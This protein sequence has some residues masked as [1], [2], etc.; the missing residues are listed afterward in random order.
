MTVLAG[1][2]S[3]IIGDK[4]RTLVLRGTSI[5]IQWGNK[6][7]DL[8]K[9]GKI[10]TEKNDILK[11]A[12][13]VEEIG[14]NGIYLVG[15]EVWISINGTKMLLGSSTAQ[16][17][18]F[19]QEQEL[20]P[21]QKQLAQS[22]MG[23][24]Y[25]TI[26]DIDNISAGIVFVEEDNSL[27]L[28]R[29]G[30]ATKYS[31]QETIEPSLIINA[32]EIIA[33][34][35]LLIKVNDLEY[36]RCEE[37]QVKLLQDTV[38]YDS[39]KFMSEDATSD[40]GFR[41][42]ETGNG[43]VLE[44]DTIILRKEIIRKTFVDVT[45]DE[46]RYLIETD[47][48]VMNTQ[49]RLTDYKNFWEMEEDSDRTEDRWDENNNLLLKNTRP[50]IVK[51]RTE[52]TYYQDECW[53]E[54]FPL[55]TISYDVTFN[56]RHTYSDGHSEEARGLITR[57]KD[58]Y[59]N[60]AN[61][62]FKHLKF[63]LNNKW[64]YT[65]SDSNGAEASAKYSNN[66]VEVTNLLIQSENPNTHGLGAINQGLNYLVFIKPNTGN[67][68]LNYKNRLIINYDFNYNDW[69]DVTWTGNEILP[70]ISINGCTFRNTF[71]D[72]IINA[73]LT[74]SQFI[75]EFEENIINKELI[76]SKF[77]AYSKLNKIEEVLTNISFQGGSLENVFKS[78]LI[79]CTFMGLVER[80]EFTMPITQC[81]FKYNVIETD[82][83]GKVE[84]YNCE[85]HSE[86]I[87][88]IKRPDDELLINTL[89]NDELKQVA[90]YIEDGE[91]H[92]QILSMSL[93]VPAGT[94]V[95]WYGSGLPYGWAICDGSNGTPDLRGMF[96]KG[97]KGFYD[98]GAVESDLDDNNMLTLKPENIPSQSNSL[99]VSTTKVA[100]GDAT[101]VI[102]A[103]SL[104]S[105]PITDAEPIKIEP[106]S[107]AL[108]FIMKL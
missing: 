44:I 89:K 10:N 85:F 54:E 90:V 50:L 2:N 3:D 57:L 53:Y 76:G 28:V 101:E 42:Y 8:I 12:N 103:V 95:M 84:F 46:F 69:D 66:K 78:L 33:S 59:G 47:N 22:N 21:E 82:I 86:V 1:K 19:L 20:T 36:V 79:D 23:L 17:I 9:N 67:T 92:L 70:T 52:N 64:Y 77:L 99:T 27:Y 60:E 48:L 71:K 94:I 68:I 73:N 5:K 34:E 61:Y 18:S 16:Y 38:I 108:L 24:Y 107:Y 26:S 40:K 65:F 81:L 75:G 37:N 100:A 106:R 105:S 56:K 29:D 91:K 6:F 31:T 72:N 39:H 35:S 25:K 98:I 45:V 32:E 58:E 13:S 14:S 30:K 43:S 63:R 87:G 104:E 11:T 62:D 80:T 74:N 7:I 41:L 97:A 51:G 83:F 15:E 96:I 55:W 4:D 49:Y 88:N 93:A 102:S